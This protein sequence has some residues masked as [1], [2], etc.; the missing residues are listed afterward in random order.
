MAVSIEPYRRGTSFNDWYTRMKYFFGV[1]KIRDDEKKAYFITISGPVI[2]AEMKLLYPAGNFEEASLDDIVSKLKSRLDKTDTDLVQRYKFSTRIQNPDESVED[3][4]LNLKLQAEFCGFENFKEVAIIDRLIAGISD[5]KLRQRLL[6]EDK[7]TLASAE[8]LIATWEVA[9]ANAG[10]AE[11]P[12]SGNSNMVAAVNNRSSGTHGIVAN[13]L[14]RVYDLARNQ[15]GFGHNAGGTSSRGPVKS[16]LGFKSPGKMQPSYRDRRGAEADNYR[17]DGRVGGQRQWQRPDYSQMICN[18]CGIKGHIRKKCFK[19]KNLN[20]DAVNL[21][22]SYR[23]GPSSDR[24]I[25]ELLSRMQTRDEEDT[26]DSDS[27]NLQCMQVSSINKIS[28]PCLVLVVIEGKSLEMEVDCG[29]S[30]SVISKRRYFSKFDNPLRSYSEPLMVVNGTK[31]RIAGEARVSVKFNGREELMQLLVLDGENDFY[32]LLGRT[33]L[34]VF[35]PNWRQFFMNGLHINNVNMDSGKIAIEDLKKQFPTVFKKNF[36]TPILGFKAELMMKDEVPIFKKAYEVPYRLK[37]KV[38]TYLDK[39][40]EQKVITP[41]ESSEWASPIIVVMKKNGEI[42]LVIDCKV[43]INKAIVPNTYP[44]PTSQDIF[45]NL[46]G[47]KIFCALDL[48]GAYTQLELTERS[49]QFVVINTMKGLY[50]YNRLPQGASSSASIF[51]RVMD[52]VLEGIE[53]VSCYLDDVLIAGKTLEECKRKL[54]LVLERLANVNIKVNFEKCKFFVTELTHLGHVI[55]DKGLRPCSD[56]I[57]TIEKANAP[58]NESELKSFLGLLNYYHKFI[59]NLSSKLYPLYNLLKNNTKYVWDDHCQKAFLESKNLLIETDLLEFYDPKKPMV[60]ISDASSY[61]LGGLIAHVVDDVEKPISFT[62]FSL[63]SAQRKYPILHLEALA[64]VCTIKKFHKYLYGQHFTVYT[65]HKPL[66]GIFGKEGRNSIFV[67]RL[68]RFVLDLS[69]YD[70][71]IIYR[72]SHKLG[73]A[74]FCSRFPLQQEVPSQIDSEA[75][76]SINFSNEFPIDSKVIAS[77]TKEDEFLQKVISFMLNGWPERVDRQFADV[78]SNYLNLELVDDCL[79]FMDRIIIPKVYQKKILKLLHANHAGI[80]KMKQLARNT[81]YWFGINTDIEK[82]VTDCEC[83]NSMA[84]IPKPKE[85]AKW[86][87]TTRPFSRIHID[88]FYYGHR[89]Y[90]LIVDSYSKWIEV[91]KMVHGTDCNKVLR[92]LVAYFARFG[93]PDVL[94]SDNGP[95][96]NSRGFV[97][98]LEKQGIKVMKSPPYNPASNGQ[99]ERLVR[100]VKEVL[101]RFLMDPEISELELEDQIN[102]FLFNYRN[103]NLTKEGVFPA[104]RIFAYKP[105]TILDLVDP[106]KH[107]KKYI[108]ISHPHDDVHS[109]HQSGIIPKVQEDALDKLTAGDEL[110]YKNH[111]PHN[112]ARWLKAIFIKK[113]SRN[114]FQICIGNAEV[115][116]HRTQIRVCKGSTQWQS[117]NVWITSQEPRNEPLMSPGRKTPTSD[118]LSAV[119]DPPNGEDNR[120]RTPKGGAKRK[121]QDSGSCLTEL[122]RS[123]RTKKVFRSDDF[124]YS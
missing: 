19:L 35:Y 70:F 118:N 121:R 51:Q 2:F 50:K 39:L 48:E 102:L 119:D 4:V 101:K 59:P 54:L 94:V 75:I 111:N 99:A 114:I 8:K 23:P 29:A 26:E 1:N 38:S 55:S 98:F 120:D 7:L 122:R 96:F 105:K 40:E 21:V 14:S 17:Q 76:S 88:F 89:T 73:N 109:R 25:N 95:P 42:R 46:A 93:L 15:S 3:F 83:C 84:I 44:L 85:I 43:S 61:G 32:P 112:Q 115:M 24:H 80:V 22:E 5:K 123:K 110:W 12:N 100:T 11:Q 117:P 87:P 81:V 66:V 37:D 71:D 113:F 20:R 62:S 18:F 45:S 27:G 60:V 67:T 108:D 74:D 33:W 64:L 9:R 34:D 65:D 31:L 72:P 86:T 103:N 116:A 77:A 79:L 92:K 68:Q 90:L 78:Y 69:I 97:D 82:Y 6:S 47:C 52:K 106:R 124:Y 41:V 58:K 91:E 107:Y 10:A 28:N 30:V 56:K 36:S 53:H 16:R 49:K 13:R 63:N 57:S 104:E